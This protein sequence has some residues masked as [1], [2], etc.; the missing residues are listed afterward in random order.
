MALAYFSLRGMVSVPLEPCSY[1]LIFDD[2]KKLNRI[3]VISC[4]Y[5][6]Q[7]GIYSACIRT[8]GGNVPHQNL[9]KFDS[10]GCD[11][12]FIVTDELDLYNIPSNQITSKRQISLNSYQEYKVVMPC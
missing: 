6:T 11:Y 1:N 8:M 2:G 10:K 3:N 5:K 7:Y 4:S 9:K 12:V